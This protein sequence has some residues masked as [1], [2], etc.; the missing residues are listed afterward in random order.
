MTRNSSFLR[1][2]L[3]PVLVLAAMAALAGCVIAP[4]PGHDG[5]YRDGNGGYY[6][7]Q[8]GNQRGPDGGDHR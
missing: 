4:Y 2:V 6:H 8:G 1:A 5:G 7:G 3:R